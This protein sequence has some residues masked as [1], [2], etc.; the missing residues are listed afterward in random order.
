[1]TTGEAFDKVLAERDALRAQVQRLEAAVATLSENYSRDRHRLQEQ[2]L[3]ETEQR[4][5]MQDQRDRLLLDI[6]RLAN[7]IPPAA[8]VENSQHN[9]KI[10][11][12][13]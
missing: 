2:L 5:K 13:T 6:D 10:N 12:N 4:E 1:M 8:S 11:E 7:T 3:A 9:G